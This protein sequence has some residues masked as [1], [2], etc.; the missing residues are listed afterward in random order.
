MSVGSSAC[1]LL[2]LVNNTVKIFPRQGRFVESV[3]LCAVRVLP[4]GSKPVW[5][6]VESDILQK[7]INIQINQLNLTPINKKS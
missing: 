5:Q 1:P 6:Y 4:K 2:M 3:V 7:I